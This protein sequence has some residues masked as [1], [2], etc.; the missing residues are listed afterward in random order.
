MQVINTLSNSDLSTILESLRPNT[1][2]QV[3]SDE[4][5]RAEVATLNLSIVGNSYCGWVKATRENIE[6][7][8]GCRPCKQDENPTITIG[9]I[10]Y[11]FDNNKYNRPISMTRIAPMT[12]V[13]TYANSLAQG[14]WGS[15]AGVLVLDDRGQIVSAQHQL[16]AALI[17][18]ILSPE[19][20]EKMYFLVF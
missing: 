2:R 13:G 19:S 10:G 1:V 5:N 7:L 20:L 17:V 8:L 3:R 15:G 16:I 6:K 18:A 12:K 9:G 14:K 4:L 11:I